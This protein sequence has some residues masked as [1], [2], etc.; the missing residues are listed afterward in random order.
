MVTYLSIFPTYPC[1]IPFIISY[2]SLMPA[3]R[4]A[5]ALC[6]FNCVGNW[7]WIVGLI[8]ACRTFCREGRGRGGSTKACCCSQ[9]LNR[10]MCAFSPLLTA[11]VGL[12][13][14]LGDTL[15]IN[16]VSGP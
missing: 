9:W 2:L 8:S 13:G 1:H 7:G 5:A 15:N 14:E 3:S 10:A 4:N 12:W 11:L 16:I 6:A